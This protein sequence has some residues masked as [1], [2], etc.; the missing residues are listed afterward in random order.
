MHRGARSLEGTRPGSTRAYLMVGD[1]RP[2]SPLAHH[3]KLGKCCP[4]RQTWK[5]FRVNKVKKT[6]AKTF[7]LIV[8]RTFSFYSSFA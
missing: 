4:P 3:D 7:Q 8:L 1:V 2:I 6:F 5:V